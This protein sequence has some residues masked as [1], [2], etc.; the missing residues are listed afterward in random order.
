MFSKKPRPNLEGEQLAQAVQ[1]ASAVIWFSPDGEIID[2]NENFCILLGYEKAEIIGQNHTMFVTS[3]AAETAEYQTLWSQLSEGHPVSEIFARVTKNGDTIWKEAS[4]VP[5]KDENGAVVKVVEFAQDVTERI[6]EAAETKS[7]LRA[8]D[9]SQAMIEFKLDGT[10]VGANENFLSAV[11]YTIDEIRGQHHRMFVGKEY[12]KS[13]EYQQF[14]ID[15][16]NGETQSGEFQRYGKGR[17]EV[18]LQATYNPIVD[19][20]GQLTSVVKSAAD[21]TAQKQLSL[22][23]LAQLEALDRSQAVIEFDPDGTIRVA[24][25]NFLGALGYELDEVVGQHHRIFVQPDEAQSSEYIA[26][27]NAL[28][29]GEFQQADYLRIGKGGESVWIQ[30]TYNP[31]KGADGKVYKVV[32]FATEITATKNA[33]FAFQDAMSR[34]ANNELGVRI[35]DSMPEEFQGL[36]DEFNS[37]LST[38]SNIISGIFDTTES[39]LPE[40][41]SIAGAATDLSKRTEKQAATLEETAASLDEM[42][43]SVATATANAQEAVETASAAEEITAA[44]LD[45]A[46]KAVEAMSQIA[47]SSARVSQITS[48]IDG[49]AFQTNLLALNAGVEAARAGKS[50]RGFAVVASEVRQLAQRSADSSSEIAELIQTTTSQVGIGVELVDESRNALGKIADLVQEMRSKIERLSNASMEQSASLG[51]IN[52]AAN[53]LDQATQQNAAMFEETSAATQTLKIEVE[54]LANSTRKFT[55]DK[56]TVEEEDD[57]WSI[58]EEAEVA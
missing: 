27:W 5:I 53:Q 12:S 32:K 10:I 50:G 8:L 34:L 6:A 22:D 13:Q 4:F 15:L 54:G 37:S 2:A 16:G 48:V 17:R 44:G 39:L 29:E 45:M 18:W 14:W 43:A 36:K 52:T 26:F 21:I 47:A 19:L 1:Q 9:N 42:T 51:E 56:A 31:I 35:L 28:R 57:D 46:Q 24:N 11:G 30:A 38:L 23:Q 25:S 49:I 55:F 41:S 40:V 7:R 3:E 33:L 58:T 20:D